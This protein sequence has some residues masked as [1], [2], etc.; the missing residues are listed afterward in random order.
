MFTTLNNSSYSGI[1]KKPI[2]K[3][4]PS[5]VKVLIGLPV[6]GGA[7]TGELIKVTGDTLC[8][9]RVM[10]SYPEDHPW[11][12]LVEFPDTSQL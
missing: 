7:A 4:Y 9:T 2:L 11:N 12:V 3:N 10:G 5:S 1:L 8:R 6:V